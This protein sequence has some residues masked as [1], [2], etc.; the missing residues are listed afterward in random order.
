MGGTFVSS[1]RSSLL[2]PRYENGDGFGGVWRYSGTHVYRNESM[3][4]CVSEWRGIVPGVRIRGG[5]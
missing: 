2:H 1:S 3:N 4:R 5:V